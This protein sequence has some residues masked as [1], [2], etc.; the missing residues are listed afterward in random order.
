MSVD[1]PGPALKRW[2]C[3]YGDFRGDPEQLLN[4]CFDAM[5]YMANWG[6]RQLRFRLPQVLLDT[7]QIRLYCVSEEIDC[8]ITKNKQH[9]IVDIDFHDEEQAYWTE[10]WLDDLVA[11]RE[12]LI[13]GDFRMLYLAWLKAAA[14][15]LAIAEIAADT[16][17]SPVPDGLGQLSPAL[18]T[19]VRFLNIDAAMVAVAARRLAPSS[20]LRARGTRSLAGG[21]GEAGAARGKK[22]ALELLSTPSLSGGETRPRTPEK[23]RQSRRPLPCLRLWQSQPLEFHEADVDHHPARGLLRRSGK[24]LQVTA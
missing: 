2:L 17:E 9:V 8:R 12:E 18:K 10:G 6:S 22:G 4:D 1:T 5:L 24:H 16:L 19:F 3:R 11:L 13:Q 23:S 7:K 15:A 14:G 20:A 21:W